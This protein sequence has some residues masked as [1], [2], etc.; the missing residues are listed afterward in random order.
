MRWTNWGNAARFAAHGIFGFLV[1]TAAMAAQPASAQQSSCP[2]AA[3][4]DWTEGETFTWNE[5]CAG[6]SVDLATAYDDLTSTGDVDKWKP[7]RT[8]RAA[9]LK[10]IITDPVYRDA[11]PFSGVRIAGDHIPDDLNL[12]DVR[13]DKPLQIFYSVLDR[14]VVMQRYRTSSFLNFYDSWFR[15]RAPDDNQS[16]VALD[17]VGA[18]IGKSLDLGKAFINGDVSTIDL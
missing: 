3:Q 12:S 7:V 18:D 2:V 17:L 16:N 4:A 15:Y 14:P 9:F 8:L 5:L 13:F 10:R 6:R 11:L 1:L